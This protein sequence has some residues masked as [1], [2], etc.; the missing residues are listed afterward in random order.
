MEGDIAKLPEIV[1]LARAPR[2]GRRGRRLPRDRGAGRHRAR[3]RRASRDARRG[4][5]HHLDARGRRSAERPAVSRPGSAA[6]VDYLIAAVAPAAVLERAS[7]DRRRERARGGALPRGA[8]GARWR[9][10]TTTPATSARRLEEMGL[11]P[12]AGRDADR[13]DHPRGDGQGDPRERDDA[14]RGR[15]RHR[16]RLSG[17]AARARARA[18][19]DLRRAH[20]RTTSTSRWPRSRRSGRSWG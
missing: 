7:A 9:G 10:F 13:P 19:P 16:I 12:L 2:R 15:V 6:L 18:L 20:A 1:A 4:R 11:K 5:R 17:R 14:R 8:P 3:N